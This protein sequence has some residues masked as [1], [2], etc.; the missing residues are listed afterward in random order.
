M[1]ADLLAR[2][3]LRASDLLGQ[4]GEARVYALDAKRV[5]RVSHV[6]ADPRSATL[7]RELLAGLDARGLGFAVPEVLDHG[8]LDGQLYT[9][10]AR[11]PGQSLDKVLAQSTDQKREKLL[12]EYMLTSLKIRKLRMP[13]D[14]YG[15]IARPDAIRTRTLMD[16]MCQRA[17]RSL[18]DI[19]LT[20]D[21]ADLTAPLQ[22]TAP[23]ALVHLDY[24]PGNVMADGD[25]IT[26]VFDFGYS[27]VWAN[28]DFTPVLAAI[29]L[30]RRITDSAHPQDL[31]FARAWLGDHDLDR[32]FAP[33]RLW[34][35]AY[36]A[37]CAG[38]DPSLFQFIVSALQPYD[39]R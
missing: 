23:P 19:P 36:W 2:F 5:L 33:L 22:S 3:G 20:I 14:W 29:Y 39:T 38:D 32:L 31:P 11:I 34:I 26:G 18:Q 1:N 35:A 12:H 10:E 30:E 21:V 37:F 4:G 28:A 27:T 6:G 13:S 9:I 25:T 15:E 24:F 17:E 16:F 8:Q 7:R